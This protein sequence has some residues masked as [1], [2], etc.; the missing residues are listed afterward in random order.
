MLLNKCPVPQWLSCVVA[1][2][3]YRTYSNISVHKVVSFP[4]TGKNVVTAVQYSKDGNFL[5]CGDMSGHMHIMSPDTGA[6]LR[7]VKHYKRGSPAIMCMRFHPVNKYKFFVSTG[8][9]TVYCCEANSGAS[10]SVATETDNVTHC[11][12]ISCSGQ[13][14]ITV[15][16]DL[17]VRMYDSHTMTLT[18]IITGYVGISAPDDNLVGHALRVFGLKCHPEYDH[19]FI[20][21]GWDN[22][23]KMWDSRTEEGVVGVIPGPHICG[24]SIDIRGSYVVSGSWVKKN[25]LQLWDFNTMSLV[26]NI[27]FRQKGDGEYLYCARFANDQTVLAGG[28]GTK[29]AQA[30]NFETD[31]VSCS[32]HR[33]LY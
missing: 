30:I 1:A 25:S 4:E 6:I 31:E 20:T 3:G 15:G 23:L 18:K 17:N 24:D 26:R 27:K 28:S 29:S 22:N 14:V 13:H 5:V 11:L 10:Q 8:N 16:K 7:P 12:D 33:N 9:G 19:I 21:G 2:L 32:R